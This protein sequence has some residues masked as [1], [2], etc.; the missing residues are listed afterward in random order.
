MTDEPKDATPSRWRWW[1]GLLPVFALAFAFHLW[2]EYRSAD[3]HGV[4][5]Y[6]HTRLTWMYA[7]GEL[8][9]L[10]DRLPWMT[11]GS[12]GKLF[13]DWQFGYH[14]FLAPFLVLGLV[15]GGKVSAAFFA[16][17]LASTIHAILR[18][19]RV[20]LAWAFGLLSCAAS[21]MHLS[22]MHLVRPTTLLVALLLIV[23]HAAVSRKPR[24]FFGW[25][26]LMLFVYDVPHNAL[27]VTGLACGAIAACSGRFAWKVA[28][29]G[30][31]AV[32]VAIPLNPGFWS[33]EGEFWGLDHGL[34]RVWDQMGGSLQAAKDGG[35]VLVDGVSVPIE[36][37]G[38][39]KAPNG[40]VIL[41]DFQVPLWMLL[42]G[43]VLLALPARR[44]LHPFVLV[45]TGLAGL[46]FWLFLAHLRF[47][48]Y[49][50]PFTLL[51]TGMAFGRVV[52]DDPREVWRSWRARPWLQSLSWSV[53][54]VFALGVLGT[55]ATRAV[56]T[57][58]Q[59]LD[60]KT[61]VGAK[62]EEPMAWLV[63]NTERGELVFHESWPGF[64]PMFHFNQW[65]H[66]VIG[67]DPYFFYQD[68][69]VGYREWNTA[70]RGGYDPVRTRKV[71]RDMG[72]RWA[73]AKRNGPLAERLREA[74]RCEE[75]FQTRRYAIFRVD[76]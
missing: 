3:L 16:S 35:F 9:P 40:R 44:Q 6:Y 4:D 76:E 12:Y 23:A 32:V 21:G 8:N 59:T 45:S 72:A 56:R 15:T 14:V 71:V 30:A 60:V 5:G 11:F 75:V 66:F 69:P 63:E 36:A 49:W 33:W 58:A 51:A 29:A 2:L 22:R 19:H 46:Y 7:T 68:D 28:L 34:F 1:A 20:P 41:D 43:L 37:P 50:I 39:F 38:E 57:A 27:A 67:L 52:G 26:V 13:A 73:I 17:F 10:S 25:T 47:F 62:F 54:V 53:L 55:H 74:P 24:A 48:E 61:G 64:A 42:L 31:A 18:S 70:A 65:N